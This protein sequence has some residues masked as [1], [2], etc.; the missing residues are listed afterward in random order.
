MNYRIRR[1]SDKD[2]NAVIDIFNYYVENSYA[3]FLE[4]KVPPDFFNA[5]REIVYGNS[6]YVIESEA[7]TVIG[8]GL[9]KKYH[10]SKIFRGVA[11]TAYFI[12][13]GFAHKGLGSLI[14]D[15]LISD[16]RKK[17]IKTLLASIS[18]LNKESILFHKKHNFFVCGRF[19]NIGSKNGKTFDVIWM[20]K[21]I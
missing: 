10:S 15:K 4:K 17:R 8:F 5:L 21:F 18:S 1:T 13:Y 16:A 9:L 7:S 14:L 12:K 19:R 2:K 11:E 20:Q 6:F 3:A